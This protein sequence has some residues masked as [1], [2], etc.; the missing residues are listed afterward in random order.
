MALL[1]AQLL[2]GAT[3]RS[4]ATLRAEAAALKVDVLVR[5][6]LTALCEVDADNACLD[7]P[8]TI[9]VYV[10]G[11]LARVSACLVGLGVGALHQKDALRIDLS[12]ILRT[13]LQV[14]YVLAWLLGPAITPR[15]GSMEAGAELVRAAAHDPARVTALVALAEKRL[16]NAKL[17]Y[18][19]AIRD[20]VR[21]L[22]ESQDEEADI[23]AAED[24]AAPAS[25]KRANTEPS[26]ADRA[27][28]A[29]EADERRAERLAQRAARSEAGP[30]APPSGAELPVAHL[31]V[32]DTVKKRSTRGFF[33]RA[34]RITF[35]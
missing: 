12:L 7:S 26:A 35:V 14:P 20:A 5:L 15:N 21:A 9:L 30:S 16:S 29:A 4:L 28:A 11:L 27:A 23:Q 22:A 1:L 34:V 10:D 31:A 6:A 32:A 24:R 33:L 25:R 17:T 2:P 18:T 13:A 19:A 8:A 3:L